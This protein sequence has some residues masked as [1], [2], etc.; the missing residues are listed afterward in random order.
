MVIDEENISKKE[1]SNKLENEKKNLNSIAN[2]YK[3]LTNLLSDFHVS[4]VNV[5]KLR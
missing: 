1:I 3:E 2:K 5:H 4:D